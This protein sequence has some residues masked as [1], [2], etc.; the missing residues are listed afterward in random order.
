MLIKL[1]N[2]SVTRGEM[3]IADAKNIA[4]RAFFENSNVI[5]NLRLQYRPLEPGIPLLCWTNQRIPFLRQL[6]CPG[7]DRLLQ[8]QRN[9][10]RANPMGRLRQHDC[11]F[12]ILYHAS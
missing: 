6:L 9:R 12:P 4:Y 1:L 10:F 7:F 5:Y 8:I 2:A 11:N 3:T